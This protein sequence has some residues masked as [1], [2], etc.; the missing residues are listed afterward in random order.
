MD[1]RLSKCGYVQNIDIIGFLFGLE[2]GNELV[3]S[4]AALSISNL[5]IYLNQST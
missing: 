3:A 1:G 2:M 4:Q 5:P